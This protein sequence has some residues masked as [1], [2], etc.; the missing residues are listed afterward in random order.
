MKSG[1]L[2]TQLREQQ[3]L[4]YD[5]GSVYDPHLAAAALAGYVFGAPTKT[6]P[7]TKKEVPTVGLIKTGILA[8]SRACKRRPPPRRSC[9]APSTI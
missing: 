5:L 9:P 1:R 6:D 3:G 4:A 2:F 7:T 8:R